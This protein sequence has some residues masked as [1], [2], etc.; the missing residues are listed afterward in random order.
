MA[1]ANKAGN[2][3]IDPTWPQSGENDDV[4]VSELATDRQGAMSPFGDVA[5]PLPEEDLPYRHPVT[6]INK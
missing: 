2:E 6:R 5:F 4:P 1:K 3:R